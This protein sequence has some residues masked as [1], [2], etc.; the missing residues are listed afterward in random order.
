MLAR[1][2]YPQPGRPGCRPTNQAGA[3]PTPKYRTPDCQTAE[4]QITADLYFNSLTGPFYS[5]WDDPPSED[6]CRAS[7]VCPPADEQLKRDCV[8][9]SAGSIIPMFAQ[10]ISR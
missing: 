1:S 7:L 2:T 3:L 6:G 10:Q 9:D 8:I 4:H 5:P